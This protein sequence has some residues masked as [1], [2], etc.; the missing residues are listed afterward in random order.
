MNWDLLDVLTFGGMVVVAA[1]IV[2]LARRRRSRSYRIAA[3]IATLAAF[4]LVWING[5]VGIIGNEANEANLLYFGVLA[6]AAV[7]TLVARLRAR[8][9]AVALYA[10]T[11]A[12]VFVGA[13]AIVM[14]LGATGPIWPRDIVMLTAFFSAMWLASAWL[15]GR[16]AK[17]ER[18]LFAGSRSRSW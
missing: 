6:V 12:Q 17:E 16:A 11:A 1:I 9:M 5:A 18:R 10:T 8:G 2:L 13:I 14:K 4:L 7:G 15:F 3:V